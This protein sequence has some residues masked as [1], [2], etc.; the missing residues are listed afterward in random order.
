[1]LLLLQCL[2]PGQRGD[3][4]CIALLIYN[5]RLLLLPCLRRAVA[6]DGV[7][8]GTSSRCNAAALLLQQALQRLS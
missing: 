6:A 3:S 1:M 2:Q 4:R 5:L 7:Q 8:V